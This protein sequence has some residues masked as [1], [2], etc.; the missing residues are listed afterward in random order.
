M[1]KVIYVPA[2]TSSL[3]PSLVIQILELTDTVIISLSSTDLPEERVVV[4]AKEARA[5]VDMACAMPS[6][7]SVSFV[8]NNGRSNN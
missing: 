8:D 1:S 4:A 7:R 3:F 6:S 5:S 2:P